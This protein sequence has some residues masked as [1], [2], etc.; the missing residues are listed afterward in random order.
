MK[1]L[2]LLLSAIIAILVFLNIAQYNSRAGLK[3][4]LSTQKE[5]VKN[6]MQGERTYRIND[7]LKAVEIN[8]LQLDK[9]QFEELVREKDKQI[10]MIRAQKN[11]TIEYFTEVTKTDSFCITKFDTIY[12]GNDTCYGYNDKYLSFLSCN[13]TAYFET[14]DTIKQT[15]SKH[16]KHKFLWWKWKVDGITQDAWSTNP[17]TSIHFQDFIKVVD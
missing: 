11:K 5:N 14:Y 17:H 7:S 1:K 16:Y 3:D 4:Q 8:A 6:L 12:K 2:F 15:I 9:K 10:E 13:D